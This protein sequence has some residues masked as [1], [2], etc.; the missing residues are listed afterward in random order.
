MTAAKRRSRQQMVT[1]RR[2]N[3]ILDDKMLGYFHR[4][5]LQ[6]PKHISFSNISYLVCVLSAILAANGQTWL[7]YALTAA[8][9]HLAVQIFV[10]F[11]AMRMKQEINI[12][13]T[14]KVATS[15]SF[16]KIA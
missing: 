15:H 5:M 13:D 3:F 10:L 1:N 7:E 9:S 12:S 8:N 16:K 2:V 6:H 4:C 11:E 14:K